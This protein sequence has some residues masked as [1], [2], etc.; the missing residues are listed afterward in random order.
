MDV[1]RMTTDRELLELASGFLEAFSISASRQGHPSNFAKG[2]GLSLGESGAVEIDEDVYKPLAGF[3]HRAAKLL[4][5]AA[6][7]E[8]AIYYTALKQA[9]SLHSIKRITRNAA[10]SLIEAVCNQG[11]T[12]Y[13]YLAPNPLFHFAAN[14]DAIEIGRV[15][16]LKTVNFSTEKKRAYPAH[17]LEIVIGSGFDFRFTGGKAIISMNP[18][19]WVVNVDA[20]KENVEEESKWLI[21]V[22][23]SY[24]RLSYKGWKVSVPQTGSKE[25]HPTRA[26]V[27]NKEHVK[28]QGLNAWAGGMEVPPWYEIDA[29]V[30]AVATTEMFKVG[31]EQIFSPQKKSLAERV[32]QGLGWLTRGRQA[33]DRSERLLYFFTAI[34]ALLSNDDKSAP[35]IQTIARHGAVLL[36]NDND[37]RPKVAAGIKKLYS[38]RSALVH[39]GTRSILW[40]ASNESQ[41]LAENMFIIVLEKADLT[42]PHTDFCDKLSSCSYGIPWPK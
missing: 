14:I 4:G 37:D 21:D 7:H 5:S 15:R 22:A 19:C 12:S 29:S 41:V 8:K 39:A 35:I 34:E 26:L 17:K 38:F 9:H 2:S 23:V 6:G 36:T 28:F 27:L 13:E 18:V 11:N 1:M 3:I 20:I 30:L 40:S 33:E 42:V 32:S 10:L 24:L 25:P 31:A 16:A